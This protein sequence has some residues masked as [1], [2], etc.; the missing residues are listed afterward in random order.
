VAKTPSYALPLLIRKHDESFSIED[1]NGVALAYVYSENDPS[2]RSLVSRLSAEDAKRVAQT[3]ARVPT[4]A[5][6]GAGTAEADA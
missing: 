3:I 5:S 2:R 6:K 4:E 1:T